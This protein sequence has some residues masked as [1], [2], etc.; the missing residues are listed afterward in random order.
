MGELATRVLDVDWMQLCWW[1]ILF[2]LNCGKVLLS[3]LNTKNSFQCCW[4][5]FDVS[6]HTRMLPMDTLDWIFQKNCC[7]KHAVQAGIMLTSEYENVS[8]LSIQSIALPPK[9]KILLQSWLHFLFRSLSILCRP[10]HILLFLKQNWR[11]PEPLLSHSLKE[12]EIVLRFKTLWLH[13]KD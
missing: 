10:A 8:D 3:Q 1:S 12:F 4:T 11:T 5:F 6:P 7:Y 2:F 9:K 13:T